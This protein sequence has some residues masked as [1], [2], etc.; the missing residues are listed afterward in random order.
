[1]MDMDAGRTREKGHSCMV[2]GKPIGKDGY[3]GTIKE[4]SVMFC[5]EHAN[6]CLENCDKC[7]HASA[8]KACKDEN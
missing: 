5:R 7:V 8:C 3:M 1:M 6:S 4:M 2:C